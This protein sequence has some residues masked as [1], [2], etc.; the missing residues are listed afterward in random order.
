[1]PQNLE[2]VWIYNNFSLLLGCCNKNM[3]RNI[4]K[5][6]TLYKMYSKSTTKLPSRLKWIIW[7]SIMAGLQKISSNMPAIPKRISERR[8]R[9]KRN[10]EPKRK[11]G[12][13]YW[14][15]ACMRSISDL[16]FKR[17]SSRDSSTKCPEA[18]YPLSTEAV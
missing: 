8:Y 1:M 15:K 10:L 17:E 2:A 12:K 11:K 4:T 13:S 9:S 18:N 3:W 16:R 5:V 7:R 6:K 14:S